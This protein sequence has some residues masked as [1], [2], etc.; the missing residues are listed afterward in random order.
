MKRAEELRG[1]SR[2]HHQALATALV[3]RR[4]D[5]QTS[6]AAVAHFLD[7]WTHH[8]QRHFEIEEAVLLPGYVRGGGDPR[9]ELVAQVLTDHVE[10]RAK[11]LR[12]QNDAALADLHALGE[13]LAEH[14]RLEEKAL[15]PLIESTL[16]PA[17]LAALGDELDR[18]EAE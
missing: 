4:A 2:D 18:A 5:E 8:G 17:A 1:L 16:D 10:I 14:V 3:L 13:R 7:F 6:G 9:H 12:L 11:A 15:F